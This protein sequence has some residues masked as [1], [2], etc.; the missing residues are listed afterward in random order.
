MRIKKREMTLI[1]VLVS[2]GLAMAILTLLAS[3]HWQMVTIGQK[4]ENERRELFSQLL[5]KQR[6]HS[7]FNTLKR[8][9]KKQHTFFYTSDSVPFDGLV[10]SY[11]RGNDLNKAFS[12]E[13]V[14]R[15]FI[16]DKKLMLAIMP[17]PKKWDA[18]TPPLLIEEL[19]SDVSA[20]QLE[21][22]DSDG[23]TFREWPPEKEELPAVVTFS[24]KIGA[25]PYK[26]K[27]VIPS[28]LK[29]V[30]L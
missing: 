28:S 29:V 3:L 5:V 26:Q 17:S 16:Q 27:I 4:A 14:A 2:L 24:M 18:G 12:N 6:I 13:V 30:A 19:A 8:P 23:N 9:N 10:L 22:M 11:D 7:C 21:F 15:F 25:N 20:F 1:E